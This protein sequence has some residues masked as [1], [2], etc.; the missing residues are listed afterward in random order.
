MLH[1]PDNALAE[2]IR[3]IGQHAQDIQE[4]E[5]KTIQFVKRLHD[6]SLS[7]QNITELDRAM[8][9][10]FDAYAKNYATFAKGQLKGRLRG[11]T[12]RI[13]HPAY[14][15]SWGGYYLHEDTKGLAKC[16][17]R[18]ERLMSAMLNATS[19]ERAIIIDILSWGEFNGR[20]KVQEALDERNFF[21]LPAEAD[22]LINET[23]IALDAMLRAYYSLRYTA[24]AFTQFIHKHAKLSQQAELQLAELISVR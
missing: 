17:S 16:K 24:D 21:V 13:L 5:D 22:L 18:Y 19:I 10:E 2:Y 23:G 4:L 6:I 3:Q 8:I 7:R 1:I 14:W 11:Y 20:A 9:A 15:L 12:K